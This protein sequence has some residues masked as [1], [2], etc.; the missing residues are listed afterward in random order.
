MNKVSQ[1]IKKC[2]KNN[3]KYCKIK[4]KPSIRLFLKKKATI[5]YKKRINLIVKKKENNISKSQK[6]IYLFPSFKKE[7][8]MK[9][10]YKKRAK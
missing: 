10:N 5:K 7:K 6:P 2:C 8:M 9:I 4:E 3:K 1:K